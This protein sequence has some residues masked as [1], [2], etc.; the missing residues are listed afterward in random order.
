MSESLF[1]RGV[2]SCGASARYRFKHERQSE[3]QPGDSFEAQPRG[4]S[5]SIFLAKIFMDY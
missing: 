5:V 1:I 2:D 4:A 3:I